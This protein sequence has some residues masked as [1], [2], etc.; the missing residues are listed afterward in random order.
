MTSATDSRAEEL[1]R[2]YLSKYWE[3]I[4]THYEFDQPHLKDMPG[5]E[6][7]GQMYDRLTAPGGTGYRSL[8]ELAVPTWTS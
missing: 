5:Y 6:F 4:V 3:S 7:H 1:G 2:K 8:G